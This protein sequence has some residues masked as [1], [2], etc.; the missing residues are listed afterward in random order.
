MEK[1]KYM[2]NTLLASEGFSENESNRKITII[3]KNKTKSRDD[4][5]N[6]RGI[7]KLNYQFRGLHLFELPPSECGGRLDD[8]RPFVPFDLA[9]DMHYEYQRT[10]S[11]YRSIDDNKDKNYAVVANYQCN[12]CESDALS[13]MAVV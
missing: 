2:P 9:E 8:I 13:D 1:K 10:R 3:T 11:Y 4:T 7:L 12:S 6:T 5:R